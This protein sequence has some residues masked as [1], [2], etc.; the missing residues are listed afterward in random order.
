MITLNRF[1]IEAIYVYHNVVFYLPYSPGMRL[2]IYGRGDWS[3]AQPTGEKNTQEMHEWMSET[4][5]ENLLRIRKSYGKLEP[6]LHTYLNIFQ[7]SVFYIILYTL[8]YSI[9]YIKLYYTLWIL[10]Y[11]YYIILYMKLLYHLWTVVNSHT[12]LNK[13]KCEASEEEF[14]LFLIHQLQVTWSAR[15]ENL[16]GFAKLGIQIHLLYIGTV[17]MTQ[18]IPACQ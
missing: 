9:L 11:K 18:G 12:I 1:W 15:S 5:Y 3:Q 2:N 14:L 13:T 7:F 8:Y 4:V 6:W 10:H 17:M 16:M